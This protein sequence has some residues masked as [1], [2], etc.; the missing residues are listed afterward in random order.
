MGSFSVGVLMVFDFTAGP[1]LQTLCRHALGETQR[2][3]ALETIV[4]STQP[5]AVAYELNDV[6][7]LKRP[8]ETQ[9]QAH[10]F[11]MDVFFTANRFADGYTIAVVFD[12]HKYDTHAL[13]AFVQSWML[14]VRSTCVYV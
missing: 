4:Q 13:E 11:Q 3:L 1:N 14:Y 9:Q 7:P 5:V 12:E 8:P 2:I 10:P 6:R